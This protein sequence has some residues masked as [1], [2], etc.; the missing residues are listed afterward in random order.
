MDGLDKEEVHETGKHDHKLDSE[1]PDDEARCL[2]T[3]APLKQSVRRRPARPR[4]QGTF[5]NPYAWVLCG[6]TPRWPLPVVEV[7]RRPSAL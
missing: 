5:R 1:D 3:P 4:Q 7:P 2:E 6:F